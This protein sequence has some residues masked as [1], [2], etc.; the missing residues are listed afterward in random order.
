MRKPAVKDES[1]KVDI[2]ATRGVPYLE[3]AWLKRL[4]P[5]ISSTLVIMARQR[6]WK[7]CRYLWPPLVSRYGEALAY[8]CLPLLFDRP[9]GRHAV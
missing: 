5:D 9:F 6:R 1:S 2:T 8:L 4:I 3:K 7:I